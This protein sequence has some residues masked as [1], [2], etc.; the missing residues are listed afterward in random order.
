MEKKET[1]NYCWNCGASNAT[2]MSVVT[3]GY[4]SGGGN[5]FVKEGR[6]H[7][8]DCGKDHT[9]F[10]SWI[11]IIGLALV[12]VFLLLYIKSDWLDPY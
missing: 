4:R 7:C 8:E 3:V 12:I 6:M 1:N 9:T 2:H 11:K 10:T 5:S